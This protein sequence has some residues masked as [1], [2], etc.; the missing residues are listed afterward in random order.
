MK[1]S[2]AKGALL[3]VTAGLAA[4]A[5]VLPI[6]TL[7]QER[8]ERR[9]E[10]RQEVE[11]DR[12]AAA[13]RA[14]EAR[15]ARVVV[16][17]A[18]G[19]Y[20][21]IRMRDVDGETVRR[22]GLPEERGVLVVEVLEGTAAA[23]AGLRPDDVIV[24]W[25]AE[26]VESAATLSRLARETPPGR[27]VRLGVLREG[28]EREVTADLAE[29]PGRFRARG[30]G[31]V[32]QLRMRPE[33]GP[34]QVRTFRFVAGPRLGVSVIGLTDQLGEHLGAEGGKGVLVTRV[35]PGTPAEAAD[36]RAGDVILSVAGETVE[37][38]GD[39]S[40]ILRGREAGPVELRILRER[41][42]RS[43]TVELE[44]P[45]GGERGE[46][47]AFLLPGLEPGGTGP[48]LWIEPLPPLPPVDLE[49]DLEALQT[50]IAGPDWEAQAE[51][52]SRWAELLAERA[53]E[54]GS[55]W[56]EA[57]EAWAERWREWAE[58]WEGASRERFEELEARLR[59]LQEGRGP[60][61]VIF[62]GEPVML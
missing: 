55:R 58:R 14:R 42:E 45:T 22:L 26:R 37:R 10:G 1:R 46:G 12:R 34:G 5:L 33:G 47:A 61:E 15:V 48:R 20:L 28:R 13:E 59:A 17:G 53:E 41:R 9:D 27:S 35:A 16:G 62:R 50:T 2:R 38:P 19:G 4:L 51:A 57:S 25:N 8:E 39:I 44:A 11:R 31:G 24:R 18:R 7:A 56:E 49:I 21:G 54:L 40:R 32:A 30:P 29:P 6:G 23:E 43:L 52:W 36:L 3:G 60:V